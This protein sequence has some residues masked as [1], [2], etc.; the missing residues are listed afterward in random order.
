MFPAPAPVVL[1][2]PP[3][4]EGFALDPGVWG[5]APT[6]RSRESTLRGKGRG[7]DQP[8]AGVTI[9]RPPAGYRP[10]AAA[11][12]ASR[13]ATGMRNGEQET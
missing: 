3:R 12:P 2:A 4:G 7:G 6:R 13:R 5:G 9:H 8:A 10:L 1:R 11:R